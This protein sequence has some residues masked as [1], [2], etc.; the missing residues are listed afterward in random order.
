MRF[1]LLCVAAAAATVLVS[2]SAAAQESAL[3]DLRVAHPYARATPPGARAG[4]AFLTIE[5]RGAQGDRLIGAASPAAGAV[6]LHTMSMDGNVMRM[7]A[8]SAIEIPPGGTV[9]LKPGGFHVMLLDLKRP[10]AAGD[11][12]PLKLT[13]ERAGSVDVIVEVEAMV[14]AADAAHGHK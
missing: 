6:E 12:F 4:G 11:R 7:R 13:F 14:P 8:V 2:G 1:A 5:N 10:L 3:K 9:A